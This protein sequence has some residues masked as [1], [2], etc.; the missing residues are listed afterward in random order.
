MLLGITQRATGRFRQIVMEIATMRIATA[1]T[2][3]ALSSAS[4]FADEHVFLSCTPRSTDTTTKFA[5]GRVETEKELPVKMSFPIDVDLEHRFINGVDLPLDHSN[6]VLFRGLEAFLADS[7]YRRSSYTSMTID[8]LTGLASLS[9]AWMMPDA[10]R[11][12]WKG[13]KG[14]CKETSSETV[15]QCEPA[16]PK[17]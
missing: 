9:A 6:A 11:D 8:R 16:S 2:Y 14:A 15:Y 10:C 17:F 1:L 7:K 3:V 5:D 4:V 12:E 13:N